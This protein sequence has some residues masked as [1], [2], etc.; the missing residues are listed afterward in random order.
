MRT[1]RK[2]GRIFFSGIRASIFVLAFPIASWAAGAEAALKRFLAEHRSFQASFT[3]E[4]SSAAKNKAQKSAGV[5][6]FQKPG[7]FRWEI[8]A[9][10]ALLIV[11]DGKKVWLYDRDLMQVTVKRMQ[12]ALGVTPAALLLGE[13]GLEK[14]AL[15]EAGE[16]DGLN[17]LEAKPKAESAE[18]SFSRARLGFSSADG[19]LRALE[20]LD[21]FGQT[22]R[23]DF[24]EARKNPRLPADWFR[25]T[26]PPGTD[27]LEE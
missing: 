2:P 9:P 15:T 23:L 12:N 22:T 27:V 10:Y 14:F 6:A 24:L 7:R 21:A 1:A 8:T 18:M 25:F 19:Q 20:L 3:Q 4:I 16:R 11:G 17:W 13:G 5:M 26:P